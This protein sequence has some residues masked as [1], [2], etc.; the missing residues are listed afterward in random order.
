[1]SRP[2]EKPTRAQLRAAERMVARIRESRRL[3]A[4]YEATLDPRQ[5]D[6]EEVPM[7]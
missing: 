1:M 4:E 6:S 7:V 2:V 5:F 3:E